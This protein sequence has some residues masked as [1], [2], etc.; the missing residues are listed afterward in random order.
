MLG[1][2][3]PANRQTVTWLRNLDKC[4]VGGK[5]VNRLVR[6]QKSQNK[7]F[8]PFHPPLSTWWPSLIGKN[9]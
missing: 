1:S 7:M 2:S 6:K 4:T 8:V 9:S 3:A 5:I